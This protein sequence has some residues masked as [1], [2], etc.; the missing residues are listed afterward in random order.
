MGTRQPDVSSS[1]PV[2]S[3]RSEQLHALSESLCYPAAKRRCTYFSLSQPRVH[4]RP[5][6][7]YPLLP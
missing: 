6:P 1:V 4:S 3:D 2:Q 5:S 7:G